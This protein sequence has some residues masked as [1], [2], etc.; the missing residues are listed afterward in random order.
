MNRGGGVVVAFWLCFAGAAH[1]QS[2]GGSYGGGDFSSPPPSG[3]S[4]GAADHSSSSGW[5]PSGSSSDSPSTS[6]SSSRD[7]VWS[8]SR[9]SS[10]Y[11]PSRAAESSLPDDNLTPWV[12]TIFIAIFLIIVVQSGVGRLVVRRLWRLPVLGL[13]VPAETVHGS[14]L[15]IGI[16]AAARAEIQAA[17]HRLAAGA[18]TASPA[19]RHTVWVETVLALRR[20]EAAWLAVGGDPLG[21]WAAP[22]LAQEPFLAT[23]NELRAR[24]RREVIRN[25]DGTVA[26]GPSGDPVARPEE[27][28]GTVVVSLVLIARR[29]LAWLDAANAASLTRVLADWGALSADDLVAFQ[30]VWSPAEENDRMSSAE[31]ETTYPDLRWLPDGPRRGKVACSYCRAWFTAELG[32]CPACGAADEAPAV[33]SK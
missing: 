24:F 4:S 17:L 12:V 15:S 3:A 28:A 31:L 32:R 7:G 25:H 23:S 5:E 33:S 2:T 22:P 29:P 20:V 21:E 6:T 9:G 26:A 8:S 27:G 30:V 1:A 14:R 16:D 19:G 10:S 13:E 18:D 11:Q